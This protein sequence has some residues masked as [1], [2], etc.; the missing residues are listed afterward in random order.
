[1][2]KGSLDASNENVVVSEENGEAF[3]GVWNEIIAKKGLQ[4]PYILK[5]YNEEESMWIDVSGKAEW[6][7]PNEVLTS[8]GYV[9]KQIKFTA[10]D[11]NFT[12]GN[13]YGI[14]DVN[15]LISGANPNTALLNFIDDSFKY[16]SSTATL[17][18]IS[19]VTSKDPLLQYLDDVRYMYKKIHHQGDET[20]LDREYT[21][22]NA[23]TILDAGEYEITA[24]FDTGK[25]IYYSFDDNYKLPK[26]LTINKAL[27]NI[28]IS[29]VTRVYGDLIINNDP[30]IKVNG[31]EDLSKDLML[32]YENMKDLMIPFDERMYYT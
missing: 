24:F 32:I 26:K 18:R 7:N 23:D 13:D 17:K 14:F 10:D 29:P 12:D 21:A 3:K 30:A 1:M 16:S 25:C 5:Y 6:L 9:I 31:I 27:L 8:V 20:F 11:K 22:L 4:V 2:L 28:S 19:R 15:V